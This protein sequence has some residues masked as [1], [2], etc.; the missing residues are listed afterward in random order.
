MQTLRDI[1]DHLMHADPNLTASKAKRLASKVWKA[2][3]LTAAELQGDPYSFRGKPGSETKRTHRD[4]TGDLAARL[5]DLR[6]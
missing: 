1:Q 2:R 3:K 6:S 5:A 4:P